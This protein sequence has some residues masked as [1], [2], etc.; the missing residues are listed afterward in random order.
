MRRRHLLPALAAAAALVL[1]LGCSGDNPSDPAT[2][3]IDGDGVLSLQDNCPFDANFTQADCDGDATGDAC[4]L[5]NSDGDVL[6]DHSD[7]CPC[8]TNADQ[9][10]TDGD[11]IGDA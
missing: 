3:D 9:A 1:S 5:S 4:D 11:G 10:D 6:P 8:D 7:N 2:A